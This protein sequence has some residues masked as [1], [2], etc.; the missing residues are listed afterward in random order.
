MNLENLLG[1]LH[2]TEPSWKDF[3]RRREIVKAL[4]ELGDLRAIADLEKIVVTD[5]Q[6][7]DAWGLDV[8]ISI[9]EYAEAAIKRIK[10]KA[11]KQTPTDPDLSVNRAETVPLEELHTRVKAIRDRIKERQQNQ[12]LS[13]VPLLDILYDLS[14]PTMAIVEL[15]GQIKEQ[16]INPVTEIQSKF[17]SL[18][19]DA[20]RR[21]YNLIVFYADRSKEQS[22]EQIE[23]SLLL[24]LWFEIRT[25]FQTMWH[26][27]NLLEQETL[28]QVQ[29]GLLAEMKANI[30]HLREILDNVANIANLSEDRV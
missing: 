14:L 22:V 24:E 19:Q 12:Q 7:F 15:S 27:C 1:Q 4:G 10:F 9:A 25:V 30:D 6:K 8:G 2:R 29:H 5:T 28:S 16:N 18:I 21:I 3:F 17:L 26:S 11:Q 13:N 20:S 23:Q